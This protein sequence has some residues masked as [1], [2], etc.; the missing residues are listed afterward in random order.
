MKK[1]RFKITVLVLAILLVVSI[2]MYL[3][4][5]NYEIAPAAIIRTLLGKGTKLENAA[6]L[7]IRLPR[8]L[9]G[10][11]VGVALS[12]AGALLQTITKNELADPGII[13]INAGAAVAAVIFISLK[14]TNYYSALGSL[15]VY[16]LP[17]MAILGASISAFII[18]FLSSSKGIKPK[19]LLLIGLGINA[20]LNA[21]ITFFTFRGG[22]GDYNR[23]L[24]WTSGSLWGAG[25]SY[26]KIIIP[27]VSILFI[28][29]ILNYKKLDVMNLS[30][31]HVISLGLD[32]NKERKKFLGYAVMLSGVATAFAG[33]IGFIGLICPNIAKRIVGS[34]HKKF[35]I[36]SAM[37]SVVIILFADAVSRNLFSPIEIPVGIAVSIFGVPYFIYLMMEEN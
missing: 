4:W 12:T 37:I 2:L 21:F 29:V 36:A 35:L 30:D 28:L 3:G 1:R 32:L 27:F 24:I 8:M 31:E 11:C 5:G 34:Y 19:R 14:T 18:Y 23:V 13:G 20:G 9:V 26:A 15:S 22:V 6:I 25:W 17:F 7:H 16:V 33:N 10:I